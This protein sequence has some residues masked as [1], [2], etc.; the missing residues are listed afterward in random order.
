M[1]ISQILSSDL[2]FINIQT[3]SNHPIF[4][5]KGSINDLIIAKMKNLIDTQVNTTHR[6]HY[7]LRAVL[8]ELA[9]NIMSYSS[10]YNYL[11][12][13]ERV[14]LLALDELEDVFIFHTCNLV[15]TQGVEA[16]RRHAE[17]INTRD[18][19]GLAD[20]KLEF[21]KDNLMQKT[22]RTGIGLIQVAILSENGFQLKIDPINNQYAYLTLIIKIFKR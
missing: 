14:G 5:Y 19:Q 6:L 15:E 21:V 8:L 13:Q 3:E 7:K 10:E 4:F 20:L 2:L 11:D 16:L 22:K 9:Q 18:L 1:N 12:T 17:N